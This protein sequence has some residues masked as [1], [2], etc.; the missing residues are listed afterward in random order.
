MS[1][2]KSCWRAGIWRDKA[3]KD[4][5]EAFHS[6]TGAGAM[7]SA[8]TKGLRTILFLWNV[9]SLRELGKGTR[10]QCQHREQC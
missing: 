2:R 3:H 5:L 4:S 8:G 10:S 7:I 9:G 1:N 6:F